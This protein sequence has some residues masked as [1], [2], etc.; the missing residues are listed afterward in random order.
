MKCDLCKTEY[1]EDIGN[2]DAYGLAVIKSDNKNYYFA[3]YGSK[4]DGD[5]MKIVVDESQ[6][7]HRICDSCVDDMLERGSLVFER[8]YLGLK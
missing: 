6:Y 2:G 3:G 7:A 4:H 1:K 8:N 5:V